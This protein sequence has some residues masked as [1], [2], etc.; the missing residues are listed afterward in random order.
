M[1]EELKINIVDPTVRIV[2]PK[3]VMDEQLR[4]AEIAGRT[5][6]DTTPSK[7]PD[8][9]ASFLS[10][11]IESGHESVIEH[12]GAFT[13]QLET[14][15]T[16]THQLVRHRIGFAYSQQSQR[17]VNSGK[18]G[19]TFIKPAGWEGMPVQTQQAF[20]ESWKQAAE[21]YVALRQS[22]LKQEQARAVLPGASRTVITV[23]GNMRAWRNFLKLRLDKHAQREIRGIAYRIYEYLHKHW[24]FL[25]DDIH[26]DVE[27]LV[28]EETQIVE[29]VT[30]TQVV[31]FITA[32][33]FY[34][35]ATGM[36]EARPKLDGSSRFDKEYSAVLVSYRCDGKTQIGVLRETAL[37][38]DTWDDDTFIDLTLPLV[39]N[40]EDTLQVSLNVADSLF[41]KTYDH[42]GNLMLGCHEDGYDTVIYEESTD[43]PKVAE[44]WQTGLPLEALRS[45]VRYQNAL[46]LAEQTEQDE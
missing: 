10:R 22:G 45:K 41:T 28:I 4:I 18:N 7:D 3:H 12:C 44:S 37:E 13:V 8:K 15:R 19:F 30:L 6:Y 23:T 35:L 33:E 14:D 39:S 25:V 9:R 26:P 32:R 17:Y 36:V 42:N 1:E 38:Y 21:K 29:P 24:P 5:C 20:I 43:D 31:H 27:D 16:V 11:I 46:N 34:E 40:P 2:T